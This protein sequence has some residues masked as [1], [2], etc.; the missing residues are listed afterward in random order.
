M[1]RT[2]KFVIFPVR[3]EVNEE[4]RIGSSSLPNI[5]ELQIA[6]DR[7]HVLSDLETKKRLAAEILESAI[8]LSRQAAQYAGYARGGGHVM[9]G[10]PLSAQNCQKESARLHAAYE[11]YRTEYQALVLELRAA[12][13][14]RCSAPEPYGCECCNTLPCPKH[15]G[16]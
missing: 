9:F 6:M 5:D 14:V 7:G 8:R 1:N 10:R 13:E 4:G 3:V 15:S 2:V 16:V 12:G 11:L